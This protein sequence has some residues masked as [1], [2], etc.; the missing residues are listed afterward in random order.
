MEEEHSLN[1]SAQKEKRRRE[2][3]TSTTFNPLKDLYSYSNTT[4][5]RNREKCTGIE[6]SLQQCSPAYQPNNCITLN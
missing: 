1:S 4:P 3:T 2:V 5:I 6:P